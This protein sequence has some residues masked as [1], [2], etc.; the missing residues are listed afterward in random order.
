VIDL[1][2]VFRDGF[3]AG[4]SWTKYSSGTGATYVLTTDPAEVLAGSQAVKL[5]AGPERW[6]YTS[7][8]S[9]DSATLIPYQVD[10]TYTLKVPFLLKQNVN[11]AADCSFY[12]YDGVT[13]W[14][15]YVHWISEYGLNKL[16]YL[17]ASNVWVQV[18][19]VIPALNTYHV[20][21]LVAN[22]ATHTIVAMRFDGVTYAINAPMYSQA[23]TGWKRIVASLSVWSE[24][25]VA[26][27]ACF[28]NI[29]VE[30]G[31]VVVTQSTVSYQSSPINVPATINGQVVPSGSAFKVN[32][33]DVIQVS[34]PREVSV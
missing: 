19:T 9:P 33:G 7:M 29:T 26:V 12:L 11:I 31:G 20:L 5:T 13:R 3:E 18:G 23:N 24:Q 8:V 28:D 27:A 10:G 30:K 22:F 16:E 32:N 34:V 17:N 4:L 21:E 6:K 1:S 2:E 25:T 14:Q 15:P